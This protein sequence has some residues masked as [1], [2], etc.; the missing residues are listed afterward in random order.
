MQP[1]YKRHASPDTTISF[2]G[3]LMTFLVEGSD[4]EGRYAL[5]EHHARK[6]GEPPPHVHANEDEAFY[7]LDGRLRVFVGR[8]TFSVGARECVFLPRR[9]A[10]TYQIETATARFLVVLEPAGFENFFRAFG[11]VTTSLEL[12]AGATVSP[13]VDTE[14]LA[15]LAGK[16]GVSFPS[17]AELRE[18]LPAFVGQ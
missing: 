12:P 7:V 16:Y 2:M 10:H 11:E 17:A 18:Q 9:I 3:G 5:L 4:T 14:R 15:A 8:E 13:P 6:G 1:P